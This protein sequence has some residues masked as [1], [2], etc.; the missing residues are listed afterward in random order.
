MSDR[1]RTRDERT[2]SWPQVVRGAVTGLVAAVVALGVAELVAAVSS[3]FRSPVIDVGDRVVDA[4]PPSVKDLAIDWFGTN[5]KVALLAGIAVV[6]AVIAALVGA[7]AT[8]TPRHRGHLWVG[9]VG[10]SAF[11]VVG[12]AS[13]LTARDERSPLAVLPS[14]VGAAAGAAALVVL[15]RAGARAG[16]HELRQDGSPDGTTAQETGDDGSPDPVGAGE[17]APSRRAFLVIGASLAAAGVAAAA[18]GRWLGAR[19]SA[20]ASRAA[21]VL[22]DALRPLAPVPAA[23]SVDVEGV[24][25][26]VTPNA[27]FYRIDTALQVPQ[28]PI[29]DWRLR[30]GG[31]VRRPLELSFREL[32]ERDVVE[33]DITLTCVSN[34]VGGGLLGSA[35][36]LG[37][38]LD[39]LLEDAGV[40]RG[41][42]QVV[43]R[44]VD[45][46][47]CGFPVSALDGRDA[48]VAFGMNGEP[49]PL[50]HGF[51][52]RLIVP[53]L[54]GY[55]SATKWLT[56]IELT[57]FDRFDQYW[58][59][60]GWDAEAPIKTSSRIDTPRGLA[61]IP[62]GTTAVAGVA[63]AQTRGISAVE[64][65]VDDGPWQRAELAAEL[66]D[67][68]WRQWVH[69]WEATPGQHSL[70]VRA[71]DGTGAIQTAERSEP[72]PNGSSGLHQIVVLVD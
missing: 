20:A 40:R 71:I 46:Y 19:F 72:M 55:V 49:L 60:R 53:G 13:A 2:R 38:R 63:W 42:D 45:G 66:N 15:V 68:T 62:A 24:T 64:V 4:V 23:V 57:T 28:V 47:T 8:G 59:P 6:L 56:E 51:P 21:V 70:T 17:G 26:F 30:V 1:R 18:T 54:Y 41:A 25:P 7:I 50:E 32:T 52:A 37:V 44:S 9:V 12:A 33:A 3:S 22:P 39:D 65:R 10:I 69:R 35:R 61:R 31:M 67:V 36:W 16:G 58:V 43:G 48:L 34:E 29:E 11:G 27:D 14:L 5:D